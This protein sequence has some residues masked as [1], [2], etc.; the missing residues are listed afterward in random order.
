[1]LE[2]DGDDG[3]GQVVRTAVALSALTG[4]AIR[5]TNVRGDRPEP[6]MRPQHVAAVEAAAALCSAT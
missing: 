5:A 1:M 2:I 3:G 4:E 6:G